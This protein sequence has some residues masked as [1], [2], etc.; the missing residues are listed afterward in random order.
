MHIVQAGI[1]NPKM[2]VFS[3]REETECAKTILDYNDDESVVVA[4]DH[5][6]DVAVSLSCS[7]STTI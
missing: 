4:H 7:I 1:H 3:R 2:G 5:L 6:G